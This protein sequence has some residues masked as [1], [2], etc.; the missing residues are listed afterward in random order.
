MKEKLDTK[1][2]KFQK[3]CNFLLIH[4]KK[5]FCALTITSIRECGECVFEDCIFMK[6]L[7][8]KEK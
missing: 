6:L 7:K 8:V 2:I 1:I 5:G 3:K 4:K